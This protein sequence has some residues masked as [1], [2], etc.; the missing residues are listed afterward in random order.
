YLYYYTSL[1]IHFTDAATSEMYTLSLHD[2]LPIFKAATDADVLFYNGLNLEGGKDGWFGKM[3][4]ATGQDW[5]N[6]YELTEGVEPEYVVSGDG[7]EEEI[8]PHAFLD[9]HVG[10]KMAENTIDA[11]IEI[12]PDNEDYY[13][14]NGGAYVAQLQEI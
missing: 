8:N 6:A 14:E 3:M 9:P 2:A 10:V 1:P 11:L 7:R 4:D 12:D 5:D 13:K